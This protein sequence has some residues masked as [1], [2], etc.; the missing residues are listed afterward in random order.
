MTVE[1][2][3]RVA[4]VVVG[5]GYGGV[6]VAK[7]LD[8]DA[9]TD[10]VLVEPKDAFVHTVATLRALVEPAFLPTIFLPYDR[11]LAYGRVVRDR[12]VQV[13]AHLVT[14]ASRCRA[15][16][17]LHRARDGFAV[18]L[19]GQERRRRHRRRSRSVPR[20]TRDAGAGRAR[21]C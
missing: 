4:V 3:A 12:A 13:D 10:I 16:G 1:A 5:G 2:E 17:R 9:G 14:L 21:V 18:S 11:M 6:N 7:A 8:A 15:P 19:S 20:G